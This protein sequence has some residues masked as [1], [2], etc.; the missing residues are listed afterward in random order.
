[1]SSGLIINYVLYGV[2][3]VLLAVMGFTVY[4]W[5][6]WAITGLASAMTANAYFNSAHF[7]S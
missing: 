5:Q 7:N 4:M 2:L 6:F 3:G 1:M